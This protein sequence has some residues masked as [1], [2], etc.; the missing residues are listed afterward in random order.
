M[1][2]CLSA[3][4]HYRDKDATHD[5]TK[6]SPTQQHQHQ[7]S[8]SLDTTATNTPSQRG[9]NGL[10]GSHRLWSNHDDHNINHNSNTGPMSSI[11]PNTRQMSSGSAARLLQRF[12]NS[13]I[14]GQGRQSSHNK[15]NTHYHTSRHRNYIRTDRHT[16]NETYKQKLDIYSPIHEPRDSTVQSLKL[17]RDD[18]QMINGVPISLTRQYTTKPI[19]PDSHLPYLSTYT[20]PP[21]ISI[22]SVENVSDHHS[23]DHS[24]SP[25][26]QQHIFTIHDS[27]HDHEHEQQHNDDDHDETNT[28]IRSSH[29]NNVYKSNVL[30]GCESYHDKDNISSQS[31]NKRDT[32]LSMVRHV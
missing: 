19:I 11:L 31:S 32:P 1:G 27:E 16:T 2:A 25:T 4:S 22:L 30:L 23:Y 21:N 18:E 3:T 15:N 8:S 10:L 7:Q 12:Y 5:T 26:Q 6:Q 28:A 13:T 14:A 29:A 20:P 9:S 24:S 17:L